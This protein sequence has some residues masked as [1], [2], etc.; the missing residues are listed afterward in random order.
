MDY[1]DYKQYLLGIRHK[2]GSDVGLTWE[3][4]HCAP[5]PDL[6]GELV[7]WTLTWAGV[8]PDQHFLRVRED[9]AIE[10]HESQRNFFS[11]HYGP[12][13][14][15]WDLTGVRPKSVIV[16]VDAQDYSGLGYHIHDRHKNRRI[17]QVQ[18]T[19][20]V[21][22]DMKIGEFVESV[23]NLRKGKPLQEAFGLV[24]R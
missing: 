15:G 21:L 11:Y 16:R 22:A 8:F 17:Y 4:A 5:K 7:G 2:Y 20:P 9:W 24:F 1:D 23:L 19:A 12:Y 18:L 13:E 14:E 3:K 6:F 10:A